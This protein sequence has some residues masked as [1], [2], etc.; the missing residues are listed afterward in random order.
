MGAALVAVVLSVGLNPVIC[1]KLPDPGLR[2]YI[3]NMRW[4]SVDVF[5]NIEPDGKKKDFGLAPQP[6]PVRN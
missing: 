2:S 3:E 4:A 5:L 6:I 1:M